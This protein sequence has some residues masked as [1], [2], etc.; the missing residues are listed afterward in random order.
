MR[1]L[2]TFPHSLGAP[3][4]GTHDC[5]QLARHLARAGARVTVLPV[6]SLGPT[7]FP[8]PVPPEPY[9]GTVQEA[10]LAGEGVRVVRVPRQPAS[11]LLDGRPVKRAV[12]ALLDDEPADALLGYWNETLFLPELL[13]Q[14]GVLFAMNAAA[15]YGP[16]FSAPG[17]RTPLRRWRTHVFLSG[18]LRRAELVLARSEFTRGELV[19]LAGVAAERV[20]VAYLGVDP[21]FGAVERAPE[22]EDEPITRLFFSGTLVAEKGLF[23]ALEALA[24]LRD[25][26]WTFRVAGWGDADRVRARAAELGIAERV[27]LVGRLDRAGMLESLAWAQLAVHP[28]HTESFGLSN[29]EAQAAGVAVVACR[30]GAVPEVVADGESGWLVPVRDVAAL[31]GALGEALAQPA[32]TRARGAAGRRRMARE[33][34]WERTAETT[35]G[36]L[37]GALS[38]RR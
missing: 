36:A 8:R 22:P 26:P 28:S 10:D 7:R 27:E 2:V 33:F 30:V 35:L 15:S 32:E 24:R 13:R 17:A 16:L 6:A 14:R 21:E 4:G 38:T 5:I 18:P 19:Q 1:L 11:Y 9:A 12:R 37:D 23:E 34:T 3:G 29:A 20:R 31:A 25:R